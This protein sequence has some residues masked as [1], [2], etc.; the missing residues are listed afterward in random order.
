MQKWPYADFGYVGVEPLHFMLGQNI[1]EQKREYLTIE[2][3]F[4]ASSENAV[5]FFDHYAK[6][7]KS[8]KSEFDAYLE[9][10]STDGWKLAFAGNFFIGRGYRFK[11]Y[12]FRR[13]M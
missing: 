3:V 10:L 8:Q 12:H 2:A 6:E 4:P 13:T 9:K 11:R 5:Q 7:Y 1:P